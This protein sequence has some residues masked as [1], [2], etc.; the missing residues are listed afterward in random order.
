MKERISL[1]GPCPE[2][3]HIKTAAGTNS[4]HA[5]YCIL[6]LFTLNTSP[7]FVQSGLSY[8]LQLVGNICS[9]FFYGLDP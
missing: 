7:A 5:N 3:L 4:S 9:N 2:T 1:R 6:M 8:N